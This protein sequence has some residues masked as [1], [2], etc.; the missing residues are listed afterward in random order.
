M[1]PTK[2][3]HPSFKEVEVEGYTVSTN[4]VE[5]ITYFIENAVSL[6]KIT[7]KSFQYKDFY[8]CGHT[9]TMEEEDMAKNHVKEKIPSTIE[10]ICP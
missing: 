1:K 2:C 10:F 9:L 3:P 7:T 5:L 6:E 4:D 8:R